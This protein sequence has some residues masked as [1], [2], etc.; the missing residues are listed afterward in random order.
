MDV[1]FEQIVVKQNTS[2]DLLKKIG[3]VV[4]TLLVIF[5]CLFI[6][7]IIPGVVG[8]IFG[9]F[10]IFL[11]AGAVYGS[12]YLLS[13]MSIE[14]EYILTNGEIDI[15][16][17]I[18]RKR[19]KRLI[20]INVRE[21]TEFGVY[22]ASKNYGNVQSTILA[23][24]TQNDHDNYYAILDHTKFGKTIVVFTPNEKIL[25]NLKQYVKRTAIK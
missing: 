11:A 10:G 7:P 13:S 15:D 2:A 16:K 5:I 21:F 24:S 19:R 12:Y 25:T 8:Q 23:C 17:I 20:T 9:S 18:A 22:D 1:F 14:Y 4:A 3:L 6:L